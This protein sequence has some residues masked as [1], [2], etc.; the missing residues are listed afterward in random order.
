[1]G[2]TLKFN[3]SHFLVGGLVALV[4]GLLALLLPGGI[5]QTVMTVSGVVVILAGIICLFISLSRKKQ[6]LPWGMLLFESVM[7]I[8][9]GI[10]AIVWSQKTV[11]V[12]I[13]IIG[14]WV[15]FIGFMQLFTLLNISKFVYKGFYIVC[16]LLAL[17]FGILMIVNPFESAAFFVTL[18][19]VIALVVG[20]MTI[21]FSLA[22]K[23]LQKES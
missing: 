23:R 12:L 1:M 11:E 9:L 8:L 19:G 16:S 4:Y 17:A 22:I 20:I 10:A 21:M 5:L 14:T 2:N 13:I 3:W 7:M 18:T 15:A 6:M